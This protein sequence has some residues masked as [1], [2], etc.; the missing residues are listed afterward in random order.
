VDVGH[1]VIIEAKDCHTTKG[2][3]MA[4]LYD[5][6]DTVIPLAERVVGRV[7]ASSITDPATGAV[8]A[9]ADTIITKEV[10]GRIAGASLTEVEVR[11]P[12]TCELERGICAMCYGHELSRRELPEIGDAVGII[13]AQSIGEPGTQLTLRTFHSGG[14]ASGAGMKSSVVAKE[15]GVLVLKDVR[16]V[17]SD[18]DGQR[19]I[20]RN[21]R[22]FLETDGVERD[23]GKVPYGSVL[24]AAQ[25]SR[26]AKGDNIAEW[27]PY[28]TPII[29]LS[30]GSLKYEDV[31]EN[32]TM[33]RE[34]DEESGITKRFITAIESSLVPRAV[35]GG[36]E[37]P[38]P[39]GAFLTAEENGD[40]KA[41]DI[42][43]KIPRKAAVSSD[44][45]GG[46]TR[47]LQVLE[48][49]K[50]RDPAVMAEITGEVKVHPPKGKSLP[51]EIIG[52]LGD[53]RTYY[54]PIE[55]QL[56]VYSGD[57]INAGELIVDG[58]I[59][60]RD[61]LRILGSEK[62]AAHVIDDV[63]K[64]YRAQGVEI[65]DKHLEVILRKMLGKVMVT[66]PGDTE[67]VTGEI[68]SKNRFVGT[69]GKCT[70]KKATE[71]PIIVSITK[72]ALLSDSWLSAASFQS[73]SLVLANAAVTKSK[74]PVYGTK[75][76]IIVGNTV[77]VGTGHAVY[78]E[79][80][81]VIP[82]KLIEKTQREIRE[83]RKK[84]AEQLKENKKI[85]AFFPE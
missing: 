76:N 62:A 31:I 20:S 29:C 17:A 15:T 59:D 25:G 11:S 81:F 4:A 66:D 69:N 3:K 33:R 35:V 58:I 23:M 73:T 64:V 50:L 72:A 80:T 57:I 46:L 37:Y 32:V 28:Q 9:E 51:V 77:P 79:Q 85:L 43:A 6:D 22:A 71:R 47:V 75:E 26:V 56:N 65:N 19:V 7:A 39:I 68:V 34:A 54:V 1:D 42:I 53:T 67:F 36:R 82:Q 14:A 12:I 78:R 45:T 24:Q 44:I 83:E 55:K 70:G 63:Q 52:D 49:R 13:A 5:G 38:L 2:F 16:T 41:G 21:G 74:D 27:D 48:M 10:A 61:V 40:V 84:E 30:E 8:L 18:G 60:A